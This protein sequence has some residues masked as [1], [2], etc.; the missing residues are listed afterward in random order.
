[1]AAISAFEDDLQLLVSAWRKGAV[2]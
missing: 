2:E 1:M